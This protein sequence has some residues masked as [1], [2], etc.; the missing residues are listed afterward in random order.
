MLNIRKT[1]FFVFFWKKLCCFVDFIYLCSRNACPCEGGYVKL[2]SM[3]R[4]L[5]PLVRPVSKGRFLNVT[6]CI[7]KSRK[8][9]SIYSGDATRDVYVGWFY[10]SPAAIIPLY[11]YNKVY[12]LQRCTLFA[13][14]CEG[15]SPWI[16]ISVVLSFRH[17]GIDQAVVCIYYL[18]AWAG[19]KLLILYV[20]A[21]REPEDR[22]KR[23][24]IHTPT[25]FLFP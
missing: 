14:I 10:I 8:F 24:E 16:H 20:G 3:E 21:M 7:I 5:R 1:A 25:S 13:Y 23:G 19:F 17:S 9:E 12:T 4:D 18:L 15:R 11:I 6:V 22:D 2:T